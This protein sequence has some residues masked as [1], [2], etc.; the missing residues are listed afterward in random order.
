MTKSEAVEKIVE[1]CKSFDDC[2]GCP[3]YIRGFNIKCRLVTMIGV[4][5]TR[6]EDVRPLEMFM[7]LT[8]K[9]KYPEA[10]QEY[11]F[12]RLSGGWA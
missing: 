2:G 7:S 10:E 12:E 4:V 3:L 9:G 8:D 11:R 5:P 1:K 6:W